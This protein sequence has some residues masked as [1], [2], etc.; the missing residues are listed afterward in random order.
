MYKTN[1]ENKIIFQLSTL[2]PLSLKAEHSTGTPQ[3]H[4]NNPGPLG[5]VKSTDSF[6]RGSVGNSQQVILLVLNSLA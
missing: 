4:R 1:F 6:G 3:L 2:N 5:P